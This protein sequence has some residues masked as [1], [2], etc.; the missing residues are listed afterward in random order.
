MTK[1]V[2]I[3]HRNIWVIV[4]LKT[5]NVVDVFFHRSHADCETRYHN[6]WRETGIYGIR[7]AMTADRKKREVASG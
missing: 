7:P 5:G 6:D 1:R 2:P 4:N 3:K